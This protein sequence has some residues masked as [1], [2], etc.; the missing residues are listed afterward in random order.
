[1]KFFTLRSSLFIYFCIFATCYKISINPRQEK[2]LCPVLEI[3]IFELLAL[4]LFPMNTAKHSATEDKQ[5]EVH[6]AKVWTIRACL[7][8]RSLGGNLLERRVT[9]SLRLFCLPTTIEQ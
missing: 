9:D 4:V 8:C 3:W 2:R 5:R 6:T 1:M 7:L